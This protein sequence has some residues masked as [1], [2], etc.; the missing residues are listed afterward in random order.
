MNMIHEELSKEI[1]GAFYEVHKVLGFG[2][3]ENVYQN[4]LYKELVNRGMK[5]ECQKELNVYYKGEIVGTYRADMVVENRII[6]E[7]KAVSSLRPEHEWQL[8]NY[9]KATNLQ[10]GL[11]LNFG[12]SAEIKRKILTY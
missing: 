5:C 12:I 11:L 8:V 3:L 2:F 4:A 10:V 1:I 9:L 7:L 6:L